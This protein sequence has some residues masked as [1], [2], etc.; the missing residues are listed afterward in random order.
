[1]PQKN[2]GPVV[3]G[4][5]KDSRRTDLLNATPGLQ[6]SSLQQGDVQRLAAAQQSV[7]NTQGQ[8]GAAPPGPPP[9]PPVD[10]GIAAPNPV[11]FAVEKVG[12]NVGA[13][14]SQQI[15][16][17]DTNQWLPFVNALAT[18]KEASGLLKRKYMEMFAKAQQQPWTSPTAT[19]DMAAV[20]D[21]VFNAIG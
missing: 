8:Q 20:E 16:M 4:V 21:E 6:N 5:G 19:V 9:V 18:S 15:T 17:I 3:S 12:G 1:M 14:P 10:T 2:P 13:L 7:D 11:D